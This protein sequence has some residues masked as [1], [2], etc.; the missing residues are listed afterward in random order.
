LS[1]DPTTSA[2]G[3][4][5]Y[6]LDL[7][8]SFDIGLAASLNKTFLS[9]DC[10]LGQG[11]ASSYKQKVTSNKLQAEVASFKLDA[12]DIMGIYIIYK[13]CWQAG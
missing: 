10:G 11:Q 6:L 12:I 8:S 7:G 3:G 5:H 2:L 1:P 13:M 9:Q 4:N